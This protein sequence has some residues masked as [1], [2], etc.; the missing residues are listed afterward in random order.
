MTARL[1]VLAAVAVLALA[2]GCAA[3][4]VASEPTLDAAAAALEGRF[5]GR[6]GFT[7]VD[8]GSGATV[9]HRGDETFHLCSTG[10]ALLAGAVLQRADADPSFLD[11]PLRWPSSALVRASPFTTGRLGTGATVAELAAAAVSQSD[12]TASN[13]LH[14]QIGGPAATT[15]FVRGLGDPVTRLDH[16]EPMPAVVPPGDHRDVTTP[17]WFARDLRLLALGPALSSSG[18]GHLVEWLRRSTTGADQ[19]RAGVPRGWP[20]GDKTG[21]CSQ[22]FAGDVAVVG[23]PGRAPVVLAVFTAPDDARN[24]SGPAAIADATRLALRA[25]AVPGR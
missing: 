2:A 15:S 18:R 6:V 12:N 9:S 5:G 1:A 19:I 20:V 23:P 14:G 17:S 7:A 11:R 13:L 8:T 21:R 4:P 10:K 24:T 25:L 22:G 3:A 16:L